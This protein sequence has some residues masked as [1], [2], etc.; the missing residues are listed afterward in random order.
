MEATIK[1]ISALQ[2]VF[3][4]QEPITDAEEP[5]LGGFQNEVLSFQVAYIAKEP[6]APFRDFVHLKIDSPIRNHIRVRRVRHVPVGLAAFPDADANY[7]RK[8]PGLFPDLL[9]DLDRTQLRIFSDQWQSLWVDVE[10][11]ACRSPGIYPITLTLTN[12]GGAELGSATTRIEILPGML[13][14]QTLRH[15]K[16]FHLDGLAHFYRE[17]V[18]TERFWQITENFLSL[19]VRRGINMILTPIHTPPLDTAVGGERLTTQLV[20]VEVKGGRYTF[21]FSKLQ[22]WV[23]MCKRCGVEYYEMAHLFTQWGACYTP[24]IMATVD[25]EYRQIFGWDVEAASEAYKGFLAAY[26]PALTAEL[27]RLGIAENTYFHISDE[28]EE[29]HLQSYAAAKDIVAP[30]LKGFTIIDAL[31]SVEFFKKGV[32]TKPIPANDHI[33]AFIDEGIPGL[34]TYYCVAQ[35]KDVSNLFISQPSARNRIFGVQLYKYDIE[36]ILQWGYNFYNNQFSTYPIDPYAVTDADGFV[37]AGDAFQVYP[38]ADGRPEE[39]LRL[40]VTQQA[41]YDLRAF[42]WLETLTDKAYVMEL[43]E[44]SLAEPI[45]FDRYPTSDSYLLNLRACINREIVRHSGALPGQ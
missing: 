34:W 23:E 22:R 19:A 18:W 35:Y 1:I 13:P 44:G 5:M 42:Q 41:L 20:D 11:D 27:R 31:S 8:K 26:L 32:L 15:T 39:S 45:R 43:I 3:L 9:V 17:P 16:W 30:Y 2:K 28:P 24:K 4:D 33:H 37:P 12:E 29:A 7:L 14:P 10:P 36:G 21:G 25:G 40:M 6:G 38:G